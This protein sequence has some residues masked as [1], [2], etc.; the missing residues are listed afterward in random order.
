MKINTETLEN[1][2][3]RMIVEVETPQLD[4]AKRRAARKIA[5]STKIPGFRPGKAPY[6]IIERHVGDAAILEEAIELLV[7]DIYPK[8]LDE[9]GLKPYSAG[10]L[11]GIPSKDPLTF[12]FIVPLEPLIELPDYRSIRIDYDL[13]PVDPSQ[14]DQTITNIQEQQAQV[15]P[16]DRAAKE[17]DEV[18]IHLRAD[19]KVVKEGE[20]PTF[21]RDRSVPVIIR[22][23]SAE[24]LT[25][26]EWPFPGFSRNLVGLN[27]SSEVTVDYTFPEDST[28]ELLRGTEVA[29][30]FTV[31]SIKERK[32]PD[33]DDEL[34][35]SMGE[36]N[37]F[38]E[39]KKDI[40]DRLEKQSA[41]NFNSEYEDKILDQLVGD[42]KVEFSPQ[43]LEDEIDSLL[44]QL[45]NRLGYQGLD[46]D[47]YLKSRSMDMDALREELKPV[48]ETRLKKFLILAEVSR[49]EDIRV[50][51]QAVQN[52]ATNML[53]QY[54]QGMSPSQAKK[55]FSQE[56]VANLINTVAS[57]M[58]IR[59]TLD[60]LRDIASGK[61]P[62]LE[63]HDHE[64]EPE[65]AETKKKPKKAAAKK[66]KPEAAVEEPQPEA[67]TSEPAEKKPRKAKKAAP[68]N[69]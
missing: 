63:P 58:T 18:T 1:R 65:A 61:A 20:S 33:L 7:N 62:A 25:G 6:N 53:G 22:P 43:M 66:S 68:A 39:M 36:Y 32:L 48:A 52:E 23:E 4:E 14:V 9:S 69:E 64:H 27:V 55:A 56:F 29:Y 60:R 51:P 42:A 44:R 49:K 3:A 47:A 38:E 37:T 50:N 57:D 2:Q 26:E 13:Q 31:E 15:T 54:S 5:Q 10:S 24:D 16:V 11:E 19:R 46:M 35:K 28:F 34:A 8:A 45:E 59:A 30:H 12:E 17:G 67:E 41:E 40:Q 21:I